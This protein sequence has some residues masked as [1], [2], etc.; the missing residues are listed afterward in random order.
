MTISRLETFIRNA[1]EQRS[2]PD[3]NVS[4]LK[5][6]VELGQ[7]IKRIDEDIQSARRQLKRRF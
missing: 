4:L 7:E 2:Q 6:V 1:R 5:A 3:V